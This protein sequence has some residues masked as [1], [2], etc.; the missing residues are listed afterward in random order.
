MVLAASAAFVSGAVVWVRCSASASSHEESAVV[1][2]QPTDADN[3]RSSRHDGDTSSD[4]N[5]TEILVKYTVAGYEAMVPIDRVRLM[6]DTSC[7]KS[8]G[9]GRRRSSRGSSSALMNLEAGGKGDAKISSKEV[10]RVTPSPTV[11][12]SFDKQSDGNVASSESEKPAAVKGAKKRKS[13]EPKNDEPERTKKIASTK[14]DNDEGDQENNNLKSSLYFAKSAGKASAEKEKKPDASKKTKSD[15]SGGKEPVTSIGTKLDLAPCSI[16]DMEIDEDNVKVAGKKGKTSQPMKQPAAKK[17]SGAVAA[18][19]DKKVKEKE[20]SVKRN[21]TANGENNNNSVVAPAAGQ[22]DGNGGLD[23]PAPFNVE[24]AKTGR[25]TC[26]TCDEKILKGEIR[27]GHT[28]LFRGKVSLTCYLFVLLLV[29]FFI[30]FV[31]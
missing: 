27:V 8:D 30:Y 7:E 3:I 19:S 9:G 22:P 2:E 25:S 11:A 6:N 29:C 31:N 4:G 17:E 13:V 14:T 24:Y 26:R 18:A 5:S 23:Q 12:S 10:V 16:D 21:S 1:L 20:V 28:P 15:T